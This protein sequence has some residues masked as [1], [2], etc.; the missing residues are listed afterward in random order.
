MDPVTSLLGI[1]SGGGGITLGDLGGSATSSA[2]TGAVKLGDKIAGSTSTQYRII[3]MLVVFAGAVIA[4][5]IW[6][7]K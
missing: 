7:K 6:R 5:K 1:S 2:T 3:K 4:Y